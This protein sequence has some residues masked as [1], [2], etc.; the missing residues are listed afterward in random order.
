MKKYTLLIDSYG[1]DS[2]GNA[3]VATKEVMVMAKSDR[4][5]KQI[6]NKRFVDSVSGIKREN[7]NFIYNDN[8]DGFPEIWNNSKYSGGM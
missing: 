2:C 7:G 6:A 3:C 5:I 1:T 4:G 8:E